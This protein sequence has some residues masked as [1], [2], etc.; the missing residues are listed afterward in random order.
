MAEY[1]I[2]LPT[3]LISKQLV[4]QW[5]DITVTSHFELSAVYVTIFKPQIPVGFVRSVSAMVRNRWSTKASNPSTQVY[6]IAI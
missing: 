3:S 1:Y 6:D 2:L 4:N 5:E